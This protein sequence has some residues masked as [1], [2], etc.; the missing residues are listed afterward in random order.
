LSPQNTG[1]QVGAFHAQHV[2]KILYLS[3][4]FLSDKFTHDQIIPGKCPGRGESDLAKLFRTRRKVADTLM[5]L[6][7]FGMGTAH[8]GEL[9]GTVDESISQLTLDAAWEGGYNQGRSHS[10]STRKP[11]DI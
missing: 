11:G 6:P 3:N 8:I 7:V 2:S 10:S 4:K 5:Q 9:Y 1:N